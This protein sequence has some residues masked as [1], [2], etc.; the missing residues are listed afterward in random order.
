MSGVST[1]RGIKYAKIHRYLADI[2]E[3]DFFICEAGCGSGLIT[4]ELLLTT[5]IDKAVLLDVNLNILKSAKELF[6]KFERELEHVNILFEVGDVQNLPHKDESF[7]IV[8]NEG[9]IEHVK[10]MRKAV[11][12]MVRVSRK[13]IEF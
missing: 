6:R 10:D 13:Y 1:V 4:L 11:K 3:S 9:V 12:E 2:M 7:D 8:F 5:G